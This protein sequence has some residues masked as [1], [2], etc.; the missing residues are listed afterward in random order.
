MESQKLQKDHLVSILVEKT[1]KVCSECNQTYIFEDECPICN[2]KIK[3]RL[4][5]LTLSSH[6]KNMM[7]YISIVDLYD[8]DIKDLRIIDN[9]IIKNFKKKGD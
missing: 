1:Q 3:E 8:Y 5:A 9:L 4:E 7:D 6:I 2:N